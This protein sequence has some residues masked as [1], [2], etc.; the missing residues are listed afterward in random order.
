MRLSLLANSI[1]IYRL[2]LAN[3]SDKLLERYLCTL[4]NNSQQPWYNMSDAY[5]SALWDIEPYCQVA[6]IC[7]RDTIVLDGARG[8]S[9]RWKSFFPVG[10]RTG[11][12]WK[13]WFAVKAM[14]NM[15]L[16]L[17]LMIVFFVTNIIPGGVVCLLLWLYIFVNTP[18][19][20]RTVYGGKFTEVQ[21]AL[22]GFEGYL[23]APTVERAIF[24]GN[25]GR[26]SW[27]TNGSPLSV[28]NVNEDGERVG[29]DPSTDPEVRQKIERSKTAKPGEM[30]VRPHHFSSFLLNH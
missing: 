23:N 8:A 24:G 25:F 2:S 10:F 7:D 1:T 4:P 17:I 9:I 16:L 27:S 15:S 13:R 22:F 6:A 29:V 12:S 5:N 19:L 30:R 18:S 26:F 11:F 3:D 14:E 20:I 21:A 28:S